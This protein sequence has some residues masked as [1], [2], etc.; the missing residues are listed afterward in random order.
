MNYKKLY[1]E[2]KKEIL[3]NQEYIKNGKMGIEEKG[4]TFQGWVEGRD[5]QNRKYLELMDKNERN[6]RN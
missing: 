3:L 6:Y 2:L 1:E 5:Y 4:D